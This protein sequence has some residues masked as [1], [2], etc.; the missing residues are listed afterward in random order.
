MYPGGLTP[1]S[2][3]PTSELL[4]LP[5]DFTTITSHLPGFQGRMER[6]ECESD[7][8]GPPFDPAYSQLCLLSQWIT[9]TQTVRQMES[10]RERSWSLELEKGPESCSLGFQ[11]AFL[12]PACVCGRAGRPPGPPASARTAPLAA[13]AHTGVWDLHCM[14]RFMAQK[15]LETPGD[16]AIT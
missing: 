5:H 13:A 7:P 15:G 2:M 9:G 3:F 8:L 1:E 11:T 10:G 12:P 4:Y 14:W 16:G 6:D